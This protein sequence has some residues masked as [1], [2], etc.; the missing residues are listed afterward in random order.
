MQNI[1]RQ[2]PGRATQDRFGI[3]GTKFSKPHTK[4][5]QLFQVTLFL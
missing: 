4:F 5:F 2:D 3:A 1:V